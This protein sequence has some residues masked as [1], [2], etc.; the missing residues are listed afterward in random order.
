MCDACCS[1]NGERT[2]QKAY[3]SLEAA[4]SVGQLLDCYLGVNTSQ[5]Q[6]VDSSPQLRDFCGVTLNLALK[7]RLQVGD[8]VV[9]LGD[10]IIQS[11][12]L[13]V[14]FGILVF[15]RSNLIL[16]VLNLVFVDLCLC[17]SIASCLQSFLNIFT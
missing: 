10:G 13:T 3:L 14:E 6:G 2:F 8:C 16:Q 12:D 15:E 11:S 1:C 4:D 7:F 17:I 9:Q 5:F